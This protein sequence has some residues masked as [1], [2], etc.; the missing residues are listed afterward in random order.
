MENSVKT[1]FQEIKNDNYELSKPTE[2]IRKVLVLFGGYLEQSEDIKREFKILENAKKND[3]A[4]IY[5]NYNQKLWLE[6]N[7]KQKLAGQLQNIFIENKLPTTDTYVGGFSS[8]GNMALL[9]SSFLTENKRFNLEPKG[10]FIVDSPIDLLALYKS[11]EKNIKRNFSEPSVQEANWIIANLEE[12]FGK[13]KNNLPEYEKNSVFS[14]R[15]NGI[16]NLRSL[17][18]TKIRLYT[19]PDKL[20]W[21]KNRMADYDQMNAYYLEKLSESL[22]KSGFTRVE[23]IP[24]ENKGYRANGERHPHSW[25]IIDKKE[26]I[27]W[28]ME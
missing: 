4:I 10:V 14:S 20:W 12:N 3:I 26:L 19:E 21:K 28:I 27:K 7:E 17:K 18:N 15:T 11:A 9:I 23:Y 1:E 8:G 6:E 5:M 16:N 2:N 25:S 22:K 24:T 13:P